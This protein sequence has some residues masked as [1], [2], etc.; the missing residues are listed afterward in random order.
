MILLLIEYFTHISSYFCVFNLLK[1]PFSQ[2]Y[3]KSHPFISNDLT[4][5]G[6]R[7]LPV[8]CVEIVLTYLLVVKK[9]IVIHLTLYAQ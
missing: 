3:Y 2:L 8:V 6:K 7:H 9:R 1:L 5:R 4:W